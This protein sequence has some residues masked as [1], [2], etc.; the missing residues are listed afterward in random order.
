MAGN[1]FPGIN[2]QAKTH[3]GW[4]CPLLIFEYTAYRTATDALHR[5]KI[6]K[7][8]VQTQVEGFFNAGCWC[9]HLAFYRT[10]TA[11]TCHYTEHAIF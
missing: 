7:G 8:K 11:K 5:F 1:A 2:P 10:N 6:G 9:R 4:L 3:G